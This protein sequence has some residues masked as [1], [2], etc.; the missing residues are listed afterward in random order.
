MG[1]KVNFTDTSTYGGSS[2]GLDPLPTG[3]YHVAITDAEIRDSQ[4][5]AGAQ[6]INFEFTVQSGEYEGRKVWAIASLLP[7]ALFTL[8]G[9]LEAL[10]YETTGN[11]LDFE[12]D[13]LLNKELIV[14]VMFEKAGT[15]KDRDGN[16][17]QHDDRNNVKRFYKL[18]S[19]TSTLAGSSS[20]GGKSS[21]LLP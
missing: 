18:E 19:G 13:D 12:I 3:K 7:H 1:I 15:Y 2:L 10:G 21:S 16:E 9:I 6:Y 14:K 17:K 8:K 5:T 20:G 4:S 11:E